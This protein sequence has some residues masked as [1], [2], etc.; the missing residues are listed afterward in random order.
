MAV[1]G[2]AVG[3]VVLAAALYQVTGVGFALVAFPAMV[4][5]YGPLD[6]LR[7]GFLLGLVVSLLALWRAW[8]QVEPGLAVRLSVPALVAVPAGAWVMSRLPESLLVVVV[9]LLLA[10][11]LLAARRS[12]TLAVRSPVATLAA[13]TTA[14][15]A[16]VASGLSAPVLAGYALST[17]WDPRRFVATAQ[18]VFIVLN[19]ASLAALGLGGLALGNAATLLP[20]IAVGAW[21]GGRRLGARVSPAG[22]WR[23]LLVVA[24]TGVVASLVREAVG[25]FV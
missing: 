16:H 14:G 12:V 15:L 22:A 21:L 3:A 2:L 20:A 8:Q 17:N 23:L 10:G 5:L 25:L 18:V 11:G 1:T 4:A 13:G 19:V 7:T 24:W 6:G 9:D